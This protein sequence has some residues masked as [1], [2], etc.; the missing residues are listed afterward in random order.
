MSAPSRARR[1]PQTRTDLDQI[2]VRHLQL[3]ATEEVM[4]RVDGPVSE[5]QVDAG[6]ALVDDATQPRLA[7]HRATVVRITPQ[8]RR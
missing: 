7:R 5:H 4:G 2:D 1:A 3:V 8:H 6:E